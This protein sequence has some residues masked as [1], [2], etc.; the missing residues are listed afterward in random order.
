ME[1]TS[2]WHSI[3]LRF[4]GA[5]IIVLLVNSTLSNL[6]YSMIESAVEAIFETTT[7]LAPILVW[8]NNFMNVIVAT[9]IITVLLNVLIIRP[10]KTMNEKMKQ[11]E[12]GELG[13]R[14][15]I[16]GKGEVAVLG[17]QLNSLFASIESFQ[18]KQEKQINLV[19]NKT[20][21]VSE[22]VNH[23]KRHTEAR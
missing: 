21:E 13:T 3:R 19:E 23:L 15:H 12:Q 1:I 8:L 20:I 16:K 7:S 10:I 5:I 17:K 14:L 4:I 22:Q 18:L 2:Y 9:I 6:I 11:F